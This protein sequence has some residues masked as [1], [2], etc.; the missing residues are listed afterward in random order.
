MRRFWRRRCWA[1]TPLTAGLHGSVRQV[2]SGTSAGH[3]KDGEADSEDIITPWKV[4]AKG[5]RGISYDRVLRQFKAERMDEHVVERLQSLVARSTRADASA[6]VESHSAAPLHHF[7]T[8][9][10]VFSHRDFL[11]ALDD[12]ERT[13]Q[14][15]KHA[16]YLYTGRGPSASSMHIGH[17]LP[18]LL[19]K[20]LQ[21]TFNLPLV[22]QI[23]DDE[24]YLFRDVPFSGPR[25]EELIR[26][27]IKDII[28]FGFNPRT[29]FIFR[30]SEYM[31]EMYPTVLPLLHSFTASTIKNTLGLQD[32]DNVGKFAFPAVQ[33]APC[34]ASTFQ[35]VL[36]HNDTPLRC[37][38][39]C[40]IDQD[41]FF[42]LTRAAAARMKQLPPALLHTKFLPALKG[43]EH[44][45]SSSSAE[46]GVVSLHDTDQ[47][48]RKKMRRAF[49]GGR[50]TLEEM[51][52]HGADLEV[53]VAYQYL[54]FFC[55]DDDVLRSVAEKYRSGAMNSGE[56]KDLAAEVI[57]QNVLRDWR[58]R[59]AKI[60]DDDVV[61]FCSIRNIL[62]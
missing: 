31:G 51:K 13:Q 40:A 44:K 57:L 34:F 38:I 2:A 48:V 28:A 30:N 20:Y 53:D 6:A 18:F 52:V 60:T 41:P 43:L 9:S 1:A 7:F 24:K 10:I 17:V 50:G 35:R 23:T 42:V 22:I 12:I 26:S 16:A 62:F 58:D 45:M 14:P 25:A 3:C 21:D 55:P 56:V 32:C 4:A 29:T 8:R 15:G 46:H 47:Q 19:T 54:H 61:H 11:K 39:P 59:R 37:I 27:N 49:S 33:A 5:P 36:Q